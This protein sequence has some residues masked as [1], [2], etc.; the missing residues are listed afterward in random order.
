MHIN[1]S[2]FDKVLTDNE[3][4]KSITDVISEGTISLLNQ[5]KIL[6]DGIKLSLHESKS[7]GLTEDD[8]KK[9]NAI[10]TSLVDAKFAVLK[11]YQHSN[12]LKK[13]QSDEKITISRRKGRSDDVMA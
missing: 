6:S 2:E 9:L 8:V 10:S 1:E 7:L 5:I 4:K 11:A 12:T 3:T 13:L